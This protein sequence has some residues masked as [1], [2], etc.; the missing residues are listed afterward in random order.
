MTNHYEKAATLVQS[1]LLAAEARTQL[2][3]VMRL[4]ASDSADVTPAYLQ[5]AV[6]THETATETVQRRWDEFLKDI[7]N[8]A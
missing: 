3:D 4:D 8:G 7:T 5:Q 2:D 1:V 6:D